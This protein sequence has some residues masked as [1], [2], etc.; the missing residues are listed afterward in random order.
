MNRG[1]L[2]KLN[3]HEIHSPVWVH[4]VLTEDEC[5]ELVLWHHEHKHLVTVGGVTEYSGIRLMHIANRRIRDLMLRPTYHIISEIYKKCGV[6]VYPEMVALNSWHVGSYQE[7]HT[8]ITSAQEVQLDI[9]GYLPLNPNRPWT[10][11]FYLN[12]DF[13]GGEGY[14]VNP[15]DTE[16][17]VNPVVGSGIIF[18]GI[19]HKHGV[20]KIRRSPRKTISYWFTNNPFRAAPD[21]YCPD[22]SMNEDTWRL[23]L[24]GKPFPKSEIPDLNEITYK[25]WEEQRIFR[26][27]N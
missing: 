7:A 9:D 16:E 4:D 19:Y 14:F 6:H 2:P 27:N 11:I 1:V 21:G 18:Q 8:D 3:D 25:D 13:R 12:D 23:Q 10:C 20:K 15:D 22:L 24:E 26:P 17:L 5:K